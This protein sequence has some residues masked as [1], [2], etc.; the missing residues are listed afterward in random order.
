LQVAHLVVDRFVVLLF[1][2]CSPF[3]FFLFADLSLFLPATFPLSDRFIGLDGA[4]IR[5]ALGEGMQ[6]YLLALL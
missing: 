2:V 3:R 1:V 4:D 5:Y 6:A